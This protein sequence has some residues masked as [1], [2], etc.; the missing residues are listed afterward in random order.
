MLSNVAM[1]RRAFIENRLCGKKPR[2]LEFGAFDNPTFRRELGDHVKY[3]DFFSGPELREMHKDNQNR[4]LDAIVDVDYVVKSNRFVDQIKERFDLLVANHVVEHIPDL[5]FWFQQAQTL[6]TRGGIAFLAVPDRRYTFD[7]F[8]PLSLAT[9]MIRAHRDRLEKPDMWHLAE[10][11]YY[12]QKVS[13]KELWDGNLP[14]KFEP[15]FSLA[16]ALIM[17]EE[18][19]GQYTDAHCWVFTADS[20]PQL[21]ADLRSSGTV[22][23]GLDGVK[24]PEPGTNEF[25]AIL[26]GH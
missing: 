20:F 1:R 22:N 11:F 13:L 2:I 8:R 26:S 17:A 3:L 21:I 7:Y 14:R 16:K 24:E 10:H 4:D 23:L 19:S 5:I 12:H 25:W 6:L 15:R 18:K 9:Q